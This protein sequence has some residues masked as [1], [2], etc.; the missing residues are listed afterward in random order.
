MA[1]NLIN[2][3][4]VNQ[5]HQISTS[6]TIPMNFAHNVSNLETQ[7]SELMAGQQQLLEMMKTVH[8]V[9]DKQ[10]PHKGDSQQ[11]SRQRQTLN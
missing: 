7:V 1:N 10:A 4:P 5:N 6:T 2:L 3:P 8:V 11:T 9:S